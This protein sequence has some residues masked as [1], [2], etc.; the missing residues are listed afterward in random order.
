M[1]EKPD[2]R[3]AHLDHPSYDDATKDEVRAW[4][5]ETAWIIAESFGAD[6]NCGGCR[7][8]MRRVDRRQWD[9]SGCVRHTFTM[10]VDAK[11]PNPWHLDQKSPMEPDE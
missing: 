8:I 1:S 4:F 11:A 9:G 2:I 7:T 5:E 10:P 3:F 6:R